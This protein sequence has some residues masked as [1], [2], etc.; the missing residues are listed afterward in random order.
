[1]NDG[2][3]LLQV[4]LNLPLLALV[5]ARI[6]GLVAFAPFFSSAEIP[7]KMRALLAFCITLIVLPLVSAGLAVPVDLGSLVLTLIGEMCI[8]LTFGLMLTIVFSGLELAG[9]LIGQQ[10]GISL[11]QVFN[12]LFNEET[13]VTGQMYFWLAMLVFLLING[14]L[15]LVTALVK[16]F[17]TMPPGIFSINAD[18]INGLTGMLQIAFILAIQVSAPILAAIFLS[19]LAIGFIGRTVPQLNILSVGFSLRT[20]LGFLLIIVCFKPAVQ[21]FFNALEKAFLSLYGLMGF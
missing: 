5:L 13:S 14:H 6:S 2:M 11:A 4:M 1:M 19:T 18:V 10:V 15:I 8:G 16:S 21:V 20:I 9:L 12:P 17:H 7:V 3:E